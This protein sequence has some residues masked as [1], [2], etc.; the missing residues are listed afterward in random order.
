M[1]GPDKPVQSLD[2]TVF[3]SHQQGIRITGMALNPGSIYNK[4]NGKQ[5]Y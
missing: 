4:V 3:I 5:V 1:V 2:S